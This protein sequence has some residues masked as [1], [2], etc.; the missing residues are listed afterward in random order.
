MEGVKRHNVSYRLLI[1]LLN[2]NRI[3]QKY[4]PKCIYESIYNDS[5][6]IKD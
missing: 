5:K 3:E 4:I 2:D 6:S 1:E